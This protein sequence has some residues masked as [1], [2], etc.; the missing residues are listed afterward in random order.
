MHQDIQPGSHGP[1]V[2]QHY[3][4]WELKQIYLKHVVTG[5]PECV[6]AC[7]YVWGGVIYDLIECKLRS[8]QH[9]NS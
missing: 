6:C 7:V 3:C 1:R 5:V 2:A 4:E 9:H 8:E